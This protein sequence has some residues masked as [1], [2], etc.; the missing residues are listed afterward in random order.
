MPRRH[1]RRAEVPQVRRRNRLTMCLFAALTT[2][3][4]LVVT[5]CSTAPIESS[6][7]SVDASATLRSGPQTA[8]LPSADVV[9]VTTDPQVTLPVTVPSVGHG[10]TTVS[11]VSRII[12][13]D[14]NATLS[15]I[16]FSLGLGG[17][18]V[19][20]DTSTVFPAAANLPLVS[21]TGHQ[22]NA[23]KVLKLNPSVVLVTEGTT[24][25]QAVDQLRNSGIPVVE[26]T[27]ERTVASTPTLIRSVAAALGVV[28]AGEQLV[29]RTQ[30]QI[31]A[32][33]RAVPDPSG[34]PRMAFLYIRGPRL[35]L[36]AGPD[37][38]ADDLI[39]NLGGVDAGTASGFTSAFT[40]VTAEK[41]LQANPQVILVMTQGAESVGGLDGV[42]AL[43]G[44]EA[45]DAGRARRVV[46]M[47]E[48][49]VLS[50]GPDVGQVLD[51]L[52]KAIYV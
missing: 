23:E 34:N 20:R 3:M 41:L 1:P 4:I 40:A 16:V 14:R 27:S 19:G 48:T 36:I 46:Q 25:S 17:K 30:S 33:K 10:T 31:D 38:G 37:S 8:G 44:V 24:P 12:A 29:A 11:D 6:G 22:L 7:E 47:D 43:P 49:E 26:F 51:A 39:A 42:L 35:V 50:F 28:P 32:A 2:A 52:A 13:I 5:G 15:N 18:V 21:N 9:P 45:T